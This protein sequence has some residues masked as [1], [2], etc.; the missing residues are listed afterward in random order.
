HDV[1]GR[2]SAAPPG[3]RARWE[4][5]RRHGAFQG[6]VVFA[7]ASWLV[8]QAADIFGL[9]TGA[10]RALGAVLLVGFVALTVG[11]WIAAGRSAAAAAGERAASPQAAAPRRLRGRLVA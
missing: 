9:P 4:R 10:V 1:G 11:A 8:L 7:S 2:M 6:A 5:L 3:F